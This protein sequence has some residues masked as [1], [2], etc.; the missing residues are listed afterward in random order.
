[1]ACRLI[2]HGPIIAAVPLSGPQEEIKQIDKRG[3]ERHHPAAQQSSS[4]FGGK[5]PWKPGSER[6]TRATERERESQGEMKKIE[7]GSN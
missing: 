6:A 1:M 3:L 2:E 4:V 7:E 5:K